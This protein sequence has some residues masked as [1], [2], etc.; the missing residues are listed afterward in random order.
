MGRNFS[1]PPGEGEAHV[2]GTGRRIGIVCARWNE[3]VTGRL[4]RGARETLAARG[5][6]DEDVDLAWVPGAFE[7]PLAAKVMAGTGRYDAVIAIGCV[8]RG[9]TAHFEY[10]AGPTAEGIMSAQLSTEVPIILGV[11]TV[12]DRRQALVRSVIEGDVSGDNKGAE[13]ADTAL[14]VA[15]VLAA[16]RAG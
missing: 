15:A 14:E 12:E 4:L 1:T 11:L 16:L 5:V 6:A 10:V 7:L 13:A 8:I 3:V 9:D 2:D